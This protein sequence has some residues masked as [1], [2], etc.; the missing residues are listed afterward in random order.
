MSEESR[1]GFQQF[2]KTKSVLP[3]IQLAVYTEVLPLWKRK[4][5]RC[6]NAA[7]LHEVDCNNETNPTGMALQITLASEGG[8]P[9]K[10]SLTHTNPPVWLSVCPNV[11]KASLPRVLQPL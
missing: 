7:I 4:V 9:T 11:G 6:S 1:L 5:D 3:C 10:I 8:P 2:R